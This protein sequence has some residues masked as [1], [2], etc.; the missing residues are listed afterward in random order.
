MPA[1]AATTVIGQ[2]PAR[3]DLVV[4]QGDDIF[5]HVTVDDTVTP[6]DL[7][8]YT[9]RAEI[10]SAPGGTLVAAF[11]ATILDATTVRLHL[12]HTESAKLTGNAVWDVQITDAAGLITTITCGTVTVMKQVTP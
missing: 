2:L 5:V 12:P 4:Y 11:T 3:A 1:K 8:T 10:R 7:T 9:A 6:I